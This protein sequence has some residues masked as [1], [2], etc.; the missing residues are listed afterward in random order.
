[1][2]PNQNRT[3]RMHLVTTPE[4]YEMA[5]AL[6]NRRGLTVSDIVRL[7]IREAYEREF[8]TGE[9]AKAKPKRKR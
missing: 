5:E 2:P 6:A 4:E 9:A 7:Q 3:R 1:M 8:G